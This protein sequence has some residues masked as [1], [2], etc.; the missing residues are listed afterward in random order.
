MTSFNLNDFLKGSFSKYSHMGVR[1]SQFEF[2]L[3]D[4]QFSSQQ[5][6]KRNDLHIS[7]GDLKIIK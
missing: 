2:G 4:T 7:Q 5:A 1:A 6:E 3:G